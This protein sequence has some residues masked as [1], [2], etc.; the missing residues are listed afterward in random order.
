MYTIP[1]STI[2]AILPTIPK[3]DVRFYL[4]GACLDLDAGRIV[5]TDGHRMIVCEGPKVAG[6]GRYIIPRDAL[7]AITK[8]GGKREAATLT[9]GD[10]YGSAGG[11]PVRDFTL[12]AGGFTVT[13]R[14][15]DG[16][17]PDYQRV[18]PK[19]FNGQITQYNADYLADAKAAL[20]EYFGFRKGIV[21]RLE[22]NGPAAGVMHVN[23]PGCFVVIM[24]MRT[25]DAMDRD[26]AA[27]IDCMIP[28]PVKEAAA[29]A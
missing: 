26:M 1:M 16:T 27:F 18:I 8:S 14:T 23:R 20:T 12:S 10:T 9:F 6:G 21:P 25:D 4:V 3:K 7:A 17:F 24:P 19:R 15:I 28:D 29:A 5:A 2:R 22:H 13:G 11:S